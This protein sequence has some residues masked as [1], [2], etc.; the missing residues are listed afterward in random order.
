MAT[1]KELFDL[2][3]GNTIKVGTNF[4]YQSSSKPVDVE[5]Y[6]SYDFTANCLFT[7]YYFGEPSLDISFFVNFLNYLHSTRSWNLN[8][9]IKVSAPGRPTVVRVY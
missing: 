1:L 9:N 6:I 7:S 2:D 3:F 8:G 4:Q 5:A